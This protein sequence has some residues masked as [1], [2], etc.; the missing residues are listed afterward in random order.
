[1]RNS[2]LAVACCLALAA[3]APTTARAQHIP[4]DSPLHQMDWG[5]VTYVIAEVLEIAPDPATRPVLFD[6]LAWTGGTTHRVWFKAEGSRTTVG[7]ATALELQALY[8]RLI[9]PFWD[10]QIG[11]RTDRAA[12]NGATA[13][14]AGAVVAL[15]GVA[16]GWFE[17]EPAVFI[18]TTG[19]VDLDLTGSYDLYLTQRLI[20]QPRLEASA[21]AREDLEFGRGAGL[22][23]GSLALRARYEIRREFAPYAGVVWERRFGET[24]DLARAAGDDVRETMLVVGLRLWW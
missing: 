14:R 23:H 20:L 9:T 15:H 13:S 1:M 10:A 11:V 8:G 24:A 18:T 6:L 3:T 2:A 16:P 12:A 17:L 5:R 22:T 21:S 4:A 19:R 7:N